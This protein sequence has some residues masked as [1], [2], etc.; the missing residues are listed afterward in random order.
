MEQSRQ[1]MT[2]DKQGITETF[3]T[4]PEMLPEML[5]PEDRYQ[6][7]FNAKV[8]GELGHFYVEK[9]SDLPEEG[10]I[11]IQVGYGAESN[12]H[13][14]ILSNLKEEGLFSSNAIIRNAELNLQESVN[15]LGKSTELARSGL[16]NAI[17]NI[18]T[19][20][21][22]K[23][24]EE[25]ELLVHSIENI[26]EF[27]QNLYNILD[28][29]ENKDAGVLKEK[30]EYL[31]VELQGARKF[32]GEQIN[33]SRDEINYAPANLEIVFMNEIEQSFKPLANLILAKQ[34]LT[35]PEIGSENPKK[36]LLFARNKLE[37]GINILKELDVENNIYSTISDD[38][39]KIFNNLLEQ[40]KNISASLKE[41][42]K[43][44]TQ[45]QP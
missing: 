7:N 34:Y 41:Q 16:E 12:L 11:H 9:S 8:M 10:F 38:F 24:S 21:N 20:T 27:E 22:L 45:E 35:P 18:N 30:L 15:Y 19:I 44:I 2:G 23:I 32:N 17:E 13:A 6:I 26:L 43:E 4:P 25:S 39:N 1:E 29:F 40:A 3:E 37:I 28:G 14:T 42:Y 5:P 31:H 33:E 36:E